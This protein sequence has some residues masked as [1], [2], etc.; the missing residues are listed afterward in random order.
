M[1]PEA[2][3]L[4]WKKRH[5]MVASRN[6]NIQQSSDDTAA[7]PWRRFLVGEAWSMRVVTHLVRLIAARRCTVL[8]TGETEPVRKC[9]RGPFMKRVPEPACRWLR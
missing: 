6:Q 5:N 2:C 9:W 7:E 4:A 3:L 1:P 8:I